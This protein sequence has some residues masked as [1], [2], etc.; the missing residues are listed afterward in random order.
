MQFQAIVPPDAIDCRLA[1]ADHLGHAVSGPD[2]AF[3][4][5]LV[6]GL[7]NDLRFKLWSN[8][9]LATAS[10]RIFLNPRQALLSEPRPPLAQSLFQNLKRL[11]D[12]LT[13]LALS[14]MQN[15]F[16]P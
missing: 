9:R 5:F 11:N 4:R 8:G 3:S 7:T 10:R 6:G 2:L 13:E 1:G 12:L 15:D 16:R 14:G